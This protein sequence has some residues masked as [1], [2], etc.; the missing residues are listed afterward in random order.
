V[1]AQGG[2]NSRGTPV[3]KIRFFNYYSVTRDAL[4]AFC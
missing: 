2:A 1:V 4:S 3:A